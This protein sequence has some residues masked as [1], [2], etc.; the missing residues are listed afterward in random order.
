MTD[1]A[2][3]DTMID[4]PPFK[5]IGFIGLGAMGKPMLAHLAD[6]LPASSEIWVYDVVESVVDEVCSTFPNRVH[7]AVSS[8]DVAE[9]SV[10]HPPLPQ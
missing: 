7:K 9:H 5:T 6:K 3:S 2:S 10:R 8:A 4:S 1:A